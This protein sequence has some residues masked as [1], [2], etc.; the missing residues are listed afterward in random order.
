M[1]RLHMLKSATDTIINSFIYEEDD[2]LLVID[3]GF[4]SE[5]PTLLS[6]LQSLGGRVDGWF[7]T[8]AHPDHYGA[9]CAILRDAPRAISIHRVYLNFP[10]LSDLARISGEEEKRT[11]DRLIPELLS[12]LQDSGI[13]QIAPRVGDTYIFGSAALRVMREHDSTVFTSINDTSMVYRL[14][15]GADRV[16]FLGDL[17]E[18]GGRQLLSLHAPEEL[19]SDYCQ[20]AHH[21]QDGVGREVYEVIRP[22][23]C[24]WPT[25]SW[26]WDNLGPNGYDSG[27]L[28]TVIVRGWMSELG[29]RRHYI[30]RDA[31]HVID[32]EK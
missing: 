22:T 11:N 18:E 3:G 12:L 9:L 2:H 4:E 10:S 1:K 17:T 6:Y 14:D 29:I 8:H 27:S 5:A 32:F 7:L 31:P 19:R 24:L 30:D 20:M 15:T 25:P 26:V 23:V 13:E 21:G 28:K 16:M